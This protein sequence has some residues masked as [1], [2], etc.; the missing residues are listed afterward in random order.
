MDGSARLGRIAAFGMVAT[1]LFGLGIAFFI[2]EVGEVG[3]HV[4]LDVIGGFSALGVLGGVGLLLLPGLEASTEQ[5]RRHQVWW[6]FVMVS[7]HLA[8]VSGFIAWGGGARSTFW[9][10]FFPTLVYAGVQLPRAVATLIGF[11]CIIGLVSGAFLSD[12]V[13]RQSAGDLLLIAPLFPAV[14]MLIAEAAAMLSR[15]TDG[16]RQ[17]REGL[18][19][20][21]GNLTSALNMTAHGDLTVDPAHQL[22]VD[23]DAPYAESLTLL[24]VSLQHT[25]ANLRDLVGQVRAGGDRLATNANELL[26]TTEESAASATQQ[27]SAVTETTSTIEEL[28]ATAAQI[29]ET[30]GA[31]A[32][33]AEMTL[34]LVSEG[35]QAVEASVEAMSRISSRVDDIAGRAA[36]LGEQS[37]EIGRILD[38][39]DDLADQTNLLALNAA[40]EAARAGEHGRGFAVVATEVRKLAERS[41]SATRDIQSIIGSIQTGTTATIMATEEGAKEVRAGMALAQGAV[42]SLSRITGV[43]DETTAAAKEI[44]LAT[45][46]QRSASDQVVAAMTQVNDVARQYAVGSKQA[47]AA[48]AELNML[49]AELRASIAQFTVA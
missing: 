40:I 1:A 42:G 18:Q 6:R 41:M 14:T 11:G 30:A 35:R 21:I 19:G 43:V 25:L 27:S 31:V 33:A 44:S 12:T 37:N 23:E 24:R 16:A 15:L 7:L 38:V 45:Q 5:F 48:A 22:L 10:L 29:E 20:H 26:A 47:A 9:I 46:Q 49:A 13:D 39:I 2:H 32:G 28:A 17:D 8:C 4:S 36:G 34:Q 3:Y